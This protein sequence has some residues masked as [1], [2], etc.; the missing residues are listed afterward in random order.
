MNKKLIPPRRTGKLSDFVFNFIENIGVKHVFMLPGGGCMHLVDSLGKNRKLKFIANLHE[1]ASA[2]AADAYSQYT[3]NIGVALV[4]TGPGGTNAITGVVASWI[5]SV[6]VLIIS[7]QV[8]RADLLV[9]K[10]VRQMGPQ[11]VDIISLVKPITKYAVTVMKPDEIKFHLEKAVYLAKEG[12]PGPVWIDI[13]LDVQG[14]IIDENKLVGFKST[15]V[16]GQT[17]LSVKDFTQKI[18]ETIRLLNQ[19]ER[20]VILVGNGVRLANGIEEFRKLIN[21]LQIPVLTTWRALDILAEE[22]DLYIGRPGSIGQRGANFAQQN[23]DLIICIGA[24]LDLGQVAFSYSNFARRAKKVI[25]DIDKNEINKITT[26]IDIAFNTDAGIFLN[27]LTRKINKI[28]IDTSKWL[29]R[30]QDWKKNYPVVLPEY[31]GHPTMVA[32]KERKYV[33][34]YALVETLSKLLTNNDIIIPGSSGSCSEITL[35]AFKVKNGQRVFNSP[36]LGA[37]GFGLPASIGACIA[38]GKK[39]TIC[40]IGDGGLQHNIQELELLKRYQLPI[41]LFVLNNNA[42]ASIRATQNRYFNGNLVACDP[43]SGLTLPDTIKIVNAYG[44]KTFKIDSQDKMKGKVNTILKYDGPVVCEVIVNP[45]LLTQPKILSEVKSD[46]K[47][48]SKP[49]EDLWPFLDRKEFKAN[50][51]VPIV[52]EY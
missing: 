49:M 33:N 39:R 42:Y 22:N 17:F 25:V 40:L 48:F 9:G 3:N 4:T 50:M 15:K 51:I 30:C 43:S 38:S 5:D 34:T 20:P 19:S 23:A 45:D 47:I 13:P 27:A 2:I 36:G 37:M 31:M 12:R 28:N 1:Q 7:G 52:K 10:G 21:I 24:R 32:K 16:V 44:L 11:E 41:K 6:P 18:T 8:K 46:G 14:A 29:K 35:Q 26:K